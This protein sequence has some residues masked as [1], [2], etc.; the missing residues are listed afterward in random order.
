MNGRNQAKKI[1][2]GKKT[3]SGKPNFQQEDFRF[4]LSLVHLIGMISFS[5]ILLLVALNFSIPANA[6][7]Q[8]YKAP[9]SVKNISEL[10]KSESRILNDE[11]LGF[12]ITVPARFGEW[13]YKI[14]EVKSLMDNSLSNQYL[15]IFAPLPGVKSNDFNQQNKNILSIRKFS[16]DEWSDIEE[17]CQEGEEEFICETTGKLI[18]SETDSNGDEWVYAYTKSSDCPQSIKTKCDL[19]DEIVKSFQLK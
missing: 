14:G 5:S 13:F 2:A 12:K 7:N 1:I 18:A 8:A 4:G 3:K 17:I 11:L 16:F 19:A 9:S 15:Q 6:E 10:K